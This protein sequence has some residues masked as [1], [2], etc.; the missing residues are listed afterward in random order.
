MSQ[1]RK[2]IK[3]DFVLVGESAQS[4]QTAPQSPQAIDV[5]ISFDAWWIQTKNKYKLKPE[6][7]EAILKHF[8]S[9]GFMDYKQFNAGLRDFGYRI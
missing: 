8:E 1:K 5:P 9:R 4:T 6:L 2:E 3:K 7:R